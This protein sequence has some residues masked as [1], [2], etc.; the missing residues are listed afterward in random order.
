MY[1]TTADLFANLVAKTN[2]TAENVKD[3]AKAKSWREKGND[4][5]NSKKFLQAICSYTE[6]AK[7]APQESEALALAYANRSAVLLHL[8][9]DVAV[10]QDLDRALA[11]KYPVE[12]RYKLLERRTKCLLNLGQVCK[13]SLAQVSCY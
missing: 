2:A 11:G 3:E 1:P 13:F 4:E 8:G 7:F 6:S 5:Y 10:M 12:K 9:E